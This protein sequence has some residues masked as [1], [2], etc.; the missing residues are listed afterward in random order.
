MLGIPYARVSSSSQ[1]TGSG[2]IR[3]SADPEAYCRARGWQLW[4]G[5]AYSD[6][7]VSAFAGDHLADG[8]LGRF[9]A[10]HRAGRFGKQPVALLVEDVDR[11]SRSFPLA[12]LPVL[13]DDI[14]NAGITLSLMTSGKDISAE[15]IRSNPMDLQEVLF[16]LSAAHEFSE[17]LS[18]RVSFAHDQRCQQI[19]AGLPVAP[20]QAPSWLEL[21]PHGWRFTSYADVV[22]RVLELSLH[23]GA[24]S[25]ARLMNQEG[26]PSPGAV[27]AARQGRTRP[28][29]W[30][31]STV[32]QLI[33]SPQIHGAR[34]MRAPG[35]A[36]ALRAWKEQAAQLRRQGIPP[37][38]WP[39]RPRQRWAEPQ[40][41]YFPALLTPDEHADLL[42]AIARRRPKACGRTDQH[43]WI[44]ATLTRCICGET[45]GA[46][47]TTS[48]LSQGQQRRYL[49]LRCR[50]VGR[51][52]GCSS[53]MVALPMAQAHLLTRLTGDQFAAM[54][55]AAA[56]G[57]R[58]QALAQALARQEAADRRV[59]QLEQRHAAGEQALAN[60]ADATVVAVLAR[61]AAALDVRLAEARRLLAEARAEAGR[62][63]AVPSLT[64]LGADARAQIGA[65]LGRFAAGGD[66]VED[67][68]MVWAQLR[69][70]GI[71]ITIDAAARRLALQIGDGPPDWQPIDAELAAYALARAATGVT[72]EGVGEADIVS[73]TDAPG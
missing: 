14:L 17:R 49:Y 46:T 8:D 57:D 16:R 44:G 11:F 25:I 63:Q 71:S 45:M 15:S 43:R 30:S 50:G 52:G 68:R 55:E 26:V 28:I 51:G 7:G 35:H 73:W 29:L 13:V 38:Q 53:P 12:I 64:T 34:P 22:R 70:L 62:L 9:L 31:Y 2:L 61:R 58:T 36:A 39:A 10:D 32:E 67:R 65:V 48:N 6:P 3:Q 40:A 20:G 59:H 27:I 66:T 60:E 47:G 1:T 56:G 24:T 72:F 37:E 5:Q 41:S 69:A 42:S 18:R 4:D 21:G 33:T 19:R 54:L 23:Q